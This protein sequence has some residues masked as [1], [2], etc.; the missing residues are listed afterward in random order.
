MQVIF[1]RF[2]HFWSTFCIAVCMKFQFIGIISSLISFS[3]W[4]QFQ[5]N[6]DFGARLGIHIALG[7]HVQSIG[8]S[9]NVY[10]ADFFYQ[11]NA[12]SQLT[13]NLN[14]LGKRKFFWENKNALGAVL[15]A[16][17][18]ELSPDFQF[19]G[20]NHQTQF[21]Y[22]ISYN[23]IWYFD[24]KQ[25]S[26]RSGAWGVHLKHFSIQHENDV[27]GGQAKDRYR[28]GEFVFAYRYES[29]KFMTSF[30]IWTGETKGSFWDKTPLPKC[31]S[32]FRSLENLPYGKTSH[33][34]LSVGMLTSLP[35]QQQ[36]YTKI[37]IDSEQ[38]RH[39]LQNRV[40]HDLIFLPKSIERK[41]PH[42]P[43]LN[44]EGKPVFS[45]EETRRSRF[46]VELGSE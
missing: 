45:R 30:K 22:G 15:L 46:F 7:T 12:S 31:P 21:N 3:A 40:V 35:L 9:G 33:G 16:G 1:K 23:Y 34:I 41:T 42:Y 5:S 18:R 2:L 17:K 32:G 25:T 20:L 26:Q 4:S 36:A 37:G 13:Y 38:L 8:L 43:R 29:L 24:A 14:E 6:P 11:I 19:H 44:E 28:T 39:I 10:Y 27:F